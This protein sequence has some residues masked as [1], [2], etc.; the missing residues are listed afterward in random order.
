MAEEYAFTGVTV[1]LRLVPEKTVFFHT[2]VGT[3]RYGAL[4]MAVS[5][6]MNGSIVVGVK[7]GARDRRY[8]VTIDDVL[9][10]VVIEEGEGA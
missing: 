8:I 10:A 3:G 4:E 6:A 2:S 5:S 7:G 9:Q 1:P